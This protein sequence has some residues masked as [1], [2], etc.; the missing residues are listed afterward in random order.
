MPV[1]KLISWFPFLSLPTREAY[2]CSFSENMKLIHCSGTA[3][4]GQIFMPLKSPANMQRREMHWVLE[5]SIY[6]FYKKINKRN[7]YQQLRI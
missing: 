7:F 4:D 1:N 6:T 2:I 3:Q 5:N